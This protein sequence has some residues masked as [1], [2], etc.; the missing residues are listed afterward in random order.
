MKSPIE[1]KSLNHPG[2]SL[3][4]QL[5]NVIDDEV[6]SY[7]VAA[8]I[9]IGLAGLEWYRWVLKSP[10]HP[11]M[12]SFVAVVALAI[13]VMK[14]RKG[15]RKIKKIKLG[16]QGEKEVGQLLEQLREMGAKVFHD[17]PGH[18][19]NLDHVV[20]HSSG[21]YVIETK[22]LSKP[23]RGEAKLVFDGESITQFGKA[24]ARDPITQ[25]T[26]GNRW[27]QVLL[28]D[29]TGKAFRTMPVVL[30]PGWYIERT[31]DVKGGDLWV[32]NPKALPKYIANAQMKLS[33]EEVNLISFHIDRYI[34]NAK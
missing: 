3:D 33:P 15:I 27:F 16:L 1:S 2:E 14:I 22:T 29:S 28:K 26:A 6:L 31:R 32:L 7:V 34:R 24:L 19:F 4:H 8:L 20:I 23:D 25:V 17:I 12:M 9:S 5:Q 18:G 13:M 21:V 11:W 10:P 30:F